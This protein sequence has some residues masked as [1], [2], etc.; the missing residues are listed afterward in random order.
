MKLLIAETDYQQYR[1]KSSHD[2]K[3]IC[4]VGISVRY[5]PCYGYVNLR[6]IWWIVL[7]WTGVSIINIQQSR[8]NIQ[9]TRLY[10]LCALD[11]VMIIA[12]QMLSFVRHTTLCF[13][14]I[15]DVSGSTGSAVTSTLIC[16]DVILLTQFTR[17]QVR[18]TICSWR[19]GLWNIGHL[20]LSLSLQFMSSFSLYIWI[21]SCQY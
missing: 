7:T 11:K 1:G 16:T 5:R 4:L 20:N 12:Q 8:E 21:H 2:C 9:H 6:M 15:G 17:R 14:I 3:I 10:L 18:R 19:T 13:S